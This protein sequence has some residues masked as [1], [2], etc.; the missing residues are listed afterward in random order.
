MKPKVNLKFTK[1]IK[2]TKILWISC[3]IIVYSLGI[4]FITTRAVQIGFAGIIIRTI[5]SNIKVPT[6]YVKS[7]LT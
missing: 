5:K 3:G 1:I 2:K 6:N 4:A 7:F